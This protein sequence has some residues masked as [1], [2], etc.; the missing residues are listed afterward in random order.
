MIVR[1]RDERRQMNLWQGRVGVR[2]LAVGPFAR[3]RSY[4]AAAVGYPEPMRAA[5]HR[6]ARTAPKR[7][8]YRAGGRTVTPHFAQLAI[9][10]G[11]PSGFQA[12]I[13]ASYTGC[14]PHFGQGRAWPIAFGGGGKRRPLQWHSTQST[15]TGLGRVARARCRPAPI[16]RAARAA[17]RAGRRR[18]WHRQRPRPVRARPAPPAT[19]RAPRRVRG[20]MSRRRPLGRNCASP[21][22]TGL[23]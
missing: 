23:A 10:V 19:G 13:H 16:T 21:R 2:S 8:G 18:G 3:R 1:R 9:L 17:N 22:R 12:V 14:P 15:D 5:E 7:R 11:G 6:I 20:S 4:G